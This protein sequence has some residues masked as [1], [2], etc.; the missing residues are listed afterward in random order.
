MAEP[1]TE[2]YSDLSAADQAEL[3]QSLAPLMGRRAV[4]STELLGKGHADP[5]R[6]PSAESAPKR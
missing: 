5:C 4:G 1:T 6:M 3:L 2:R